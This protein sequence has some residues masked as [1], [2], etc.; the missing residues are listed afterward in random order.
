MTPAQP[1]REERKTTKGGESLPTGPAAAAILSAGVGCSVLGI[2]S[3]AA[4]ASKPI[5]RLMTLYRPTGPLSGVSS[6]AILIWLGTWFILAKRWQIRTVA[7]AKV[8]V[9][10][11]LLLVLGILLTFPPFGDLL[12]GK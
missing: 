8:N 3:V 4:D 6:L 2:L 7:I 12:Q 9:T 10:A 11:F 1:D 5:A